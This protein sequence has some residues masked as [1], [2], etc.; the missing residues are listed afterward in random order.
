MDLRPVGKAGSTAQL[1]LRRGTSM[2][3]G[4]MF[5][6]VERLAAV[7]GGEPIDVLLRLCLESWNGRQSAKGKIVDFQ[8]SS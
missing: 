1:Q 5:G 7:P 8:L 6:G 3:S 2:V 4:V